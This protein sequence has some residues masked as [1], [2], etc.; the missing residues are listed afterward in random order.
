MTLVRMTASFVILHGWTL[1]SPKSLIQRSTIFVV[2]DT[3]S[4]YVTSLEQRLELYEW[5]FKELYAKFPKDALGRMSGPLEYNGNGVIEWLKRDPVTGPHP[6]DASQVFGASS[7][8]KLP[9]Q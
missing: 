9:R 7:E 5:G 3:N 8:Y 2:D 4:R 1:Q 6:A